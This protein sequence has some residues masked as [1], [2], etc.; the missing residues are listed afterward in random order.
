MKFINIHTHQNSF[1]ENVVAI[2]NYYPDKDSLADFSENV[3]FSIGLHPWFIKPETVISDIRLVRQYAPPNTCLAIG[4]TGLDK[5]ITVDLNLQKFV[6]LSHLQ[7]ARDVSKPVIVHCV[8]AFAE[9]IQLYKPFTG[10]V[11]L[12]FHGFNKNQ[13]IANKLLEDGHFLSFG[14]AILNPGSNAAKI[15]TEISTDRFFL[16][17]DDAVTPVT[18][19]YQAA[20]QLK[21]MSVE[22][23]KIKVFHNF[24]TCFETKV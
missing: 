17:T 7:I 9:I 3:P 18:E 1:E 10:K 5:N 8:R 24:E 19:I 13:L 11:K 22:E 23:L 14:K 2:R 4:E 12:I 6:F 20:A 15:F 21:N 16:E